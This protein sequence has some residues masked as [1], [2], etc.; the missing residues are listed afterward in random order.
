MAKKKTEEVKVE[1][2][3][4]NPLRNYVD[5]EVKYLTNYKYDDWG[6]A[7]YAHE[8]DSG[9]DLRAAIYDPI[10]LKPGDRRIIP[11]GIKVN[12]PINHEIQVRP[13]GGNSIK[14]GVVILNTPGT[15]DEPYKGEIGILIGNG[16]LTGLSDLLLRMNA[17]GVN[18]TVDILEWIQ[19]NTVTITPGMLLA[20]AV[21][22]EVKTAIIKRTNDVGTSER[23]DRAYGSTEK[24]G[25]Y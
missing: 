2:M 23:G 7:R 18:A 10:E 1:E 20:Q 9:F 14:M 3:N 15:V 16:S 8:G 24:R 21:L 5:L 4:L 11:S 19:K 13:R 25:D 12:L 22:A 6:D 17:V